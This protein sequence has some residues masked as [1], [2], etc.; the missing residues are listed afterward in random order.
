MWLQ[1]QEDLYELHG[2]HKEKT[3]VD[4]QM[5]KRKESNQII[6]KELNKRRKRGVKRTSKHTE[7][8][9]VKI[10]KSVMTVNNYFKCK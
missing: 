7:N 4:K 10:V 2:N 1:I 9:K 8:N 6:T 5:I 3:S